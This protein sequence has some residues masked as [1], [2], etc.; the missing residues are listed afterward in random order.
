MLDS[1]RE[2]GE[3]IGRKGALMPSQ[4]REARQMM[5][6]GKGADYDSPS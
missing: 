6:A 3:P 2:R 1:K 4:V 5:V